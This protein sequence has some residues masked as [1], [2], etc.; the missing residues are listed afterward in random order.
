MLSTV[1]RLLRLIVSWLGLNR[2]S[3]PVKTLPPV[4]A[5][6][7]LPPVLPSVPA[8]A[9]V[10][11][12]GD[13]PVYVRK[14]TLLTYQEKRFYHVLLQ[15]TDAG[16]VVFCKVRLGDLVE[17]VKEPTDPQY[18]RGEAWAKHIDFVICDRYSFAP[19]LTIELDD[20]SHEKF[21]STIKSDA[22]K[23]RVLD[24]AGLPLLRVKTSNNY[25]LA[26]LE[27]QIARLIN[28]GLPDPADS[29]N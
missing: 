6:P 9:P 19:L 16:H 7:V 4:R 12:S 25:D 24:D 13:P 18:S 14:E 22:V 1:Q 17:M 2:P 5:A 21:E 20:S 26:A 23:N 15:V 8:L 3:A 27:Q 11:I 28:A 29:D 10:P